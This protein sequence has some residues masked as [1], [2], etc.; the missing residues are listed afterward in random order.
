M[1]NKKCNCEKEVNS[2]KQHLLEKHPLQNRLKK[3]D[4][5]KRRDSEKVAHSKSRFITK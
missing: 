5:L 3:L 1:I 2:G 4:S